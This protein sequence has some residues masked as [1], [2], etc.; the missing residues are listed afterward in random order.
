M[1]SPGLRGPQSSLAILL[2]RDERFWSWEQSI[3][4][5][6]LTRWDPETQEEQNATLRPQACPASARGTPTLRLS[7]GQLEAVMCI[8]HL[9]QPGSRGPPCFT[10]LVNLRRKLLHCTQ[11]SPRVSTTETGSWGGHGA[12]P[13][14]QRLVTRSHVHA[15]R[16][17]VWGCEGA[18]I[19]E[20]ETTIK[21]FWVKSGP[22]ARSRS[23]QMLAL[24]GPGQAHAWGRPRPWEGG[25]FEKDEIQ[26]GLQGESM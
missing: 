26:P 12:R 6:W 3:S 1:K 8:L 18:F 4:Q 9:Q 19:S 11:A 20:A 21:L 22:L 2:S 23:K 10:V 17:L 14:E 16:G 7:W 15:P 24:A 5:Q 13:S 25:S